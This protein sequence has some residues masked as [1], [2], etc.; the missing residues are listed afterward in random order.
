MGLNPT[1]LRQAAAF[2]SALAF[3]P[4]AATSRHP[5]RASGLVLGRVLS[6]YASDMNGRFAQ[7]P[8][9]RRGLGER[10]KSTHS[11]SSRPPPAQTG[12]ALSRSFPIRSISRFMVSG[13]RPARLKDA[14]RRCACGRTSSA[15]CASP[16]TFSTLVSCRAACLAMPRT[17]F[18]RKDLRRRRTT[19]N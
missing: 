10:V 8:V 11:G 17:A 9:I 16:A 5:Y 1:I 6:V 2:V 14:S 13:R 18:L 15:P 19:V 7:I 12:C 3:Q 4:P